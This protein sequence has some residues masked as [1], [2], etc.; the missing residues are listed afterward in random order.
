MKIKTNLVSIH[1]QNFTFSAAHLKREGN[2]T[3]TYNKRS[4]KKKLCIGHRPFPPVELCSFYWHKKYEIYYL[5]G[6]GGLINRH[7]AEF[8]VIFLT[9]STIVLDHR[10]VV[11]NAYKGF[12]ILNEVFKEFNSSS[13]EMYSR[14]KWP[15][16]FFI[17]IFYLNLPFWVLLK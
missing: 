12:L 4:F 8:F 15:S 3:L 1:K 6:R 13:T 7:A 10:I 14:Y 5:R 17:F 11:L 2:S 9:S 16:F